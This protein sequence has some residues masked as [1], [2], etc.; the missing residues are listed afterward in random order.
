MEDKTEAF[1]L[2]GD[3]YITKPFRVEEL[4]LRINAC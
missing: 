4:L 2:G 1:E 3:D